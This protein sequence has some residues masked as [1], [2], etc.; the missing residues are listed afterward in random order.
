MV[1][2]RKLANMSLA[3]AAQ[4]FHKKSQI[5]GTKYRLLQ[6]QKSTPRPPACPFLNLDSEL[7]Q[8]FFCLARD[9]MLQLF[10]LILDLVQ[11]VDQPLKF[12]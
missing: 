1:L 2:S 8:E 3:S 4:N 7:H 11:A 5:P 10:Q 6:K 12:L 9:G